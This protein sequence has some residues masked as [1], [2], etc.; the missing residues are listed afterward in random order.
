MPTSP[1]TSLRI[2]CAF[3]RF[4]RCKFKIRSFL[5]KKSSDKYQT[6][7]ECAFRMKTGLFCP[8]DAVAEYIEFKFVGFRK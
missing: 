5:G 1:L 3:S 2:T 6:K 8:V 4:G 7:S